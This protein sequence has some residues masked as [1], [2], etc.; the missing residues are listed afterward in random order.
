M[1][2][3]SCSSVRRRLEAWHDGRLR[4]A[5]QCAIDQHLDGCP[6]CAAEAK[7]LKDIGAALRGHAAVRAPSTDAL[8]GLRTAVL[9]RATAEDATSW[10]SVAADVFQDMHFVWAGLSATAATLLC[11]ALLGGMA[12]FTS[13]ERSDSLSGI[14]SALAVP[15][16]D[17]AVVAIDPRMQP[18]R[19]AGVPAMLP[20]TAEEDLVFALA[21][22]VTQEGR[23]PRSR[24]QLLLANRTDREAVLRLMNA[25]AAAKF[26]PARF[27]DEGVPVKLVALRRA[28]TG[29][30]HVPFFLTHTTVRG[31]ADS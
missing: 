13:P 6:P 8:A 15:V 28:S 17:R 25:V 24:S 14:I 4:P 5:E 20:P 23:V 11:A 31:K 12:Y 27:G 21:A 22:V 3:I 29:S 26:E 16:S 1:S 19:A 9:G 2:V 18:P 10:K 30:P 7:V